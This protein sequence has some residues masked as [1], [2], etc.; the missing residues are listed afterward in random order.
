M[1]Y[2][3]IRDWVTDGS[4][5]A[6]VDGGLGIFP[7]FLGAGAGVLSLLDRYLPTPEQDAQREL[8]RYQ[9]V[10]EGPAHP[11]DPTIWLPLAGLLAVTGAVYFLSKR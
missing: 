6:S 2:A 9:S 4:V 5:D 11:V 3:V 7:A 1:S 8:D 10:D